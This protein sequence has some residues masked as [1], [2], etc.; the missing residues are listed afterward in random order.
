MITET[1]IQKEATE[2][3]KFCDV[4]GIEIKM[5]LACSSTYC[6]YCRKDLCESCI[7]HEDLTPGDYREVYC[8]N[9]WELGNEYRPIIE[10]LSIKISSLYDEWE[11]KCKGKVK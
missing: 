2:R 8:K 10:K 5:G 6:M 9:C 11:D 4:C 3:H 1:I 7:G